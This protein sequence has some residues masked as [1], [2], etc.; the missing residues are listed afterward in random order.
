MLLEM[1]VIFAAAQLLLL[2]LG[3]AAFMTWRLRTVR[4][5]N[6]EL[7]AS[8]EAA[9]AALEE[10]RKLLETRGATRDWQQELNMRLEVLD[11]EAGSAEPLGPVNA[12]RRLVLRSEL[13][14]EPFDIA[15]LLAPSGGNDPES[16]AAIDALK[17][18]NA[19]LEAELT[20]LRAGRAIAGSASAGAGAPVNIE[21]ERELKSLVQQFTRDSREML[22]CI[23]SLESENKELRA[24][25]G[26]T[27]KSAA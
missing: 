6:V 4:R 10:G 11:G 17:A 15:P 3:F 23:Q 13:S 7:E 27:V 18:T 24:G 9:G 20:A 25:T 1:W 2:A 26:S 8:C 12:I 5:G 21:R 16:A 19:T 14:G 22:A